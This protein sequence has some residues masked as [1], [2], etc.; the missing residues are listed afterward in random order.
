MKKLNMYLH[1]LCNSGCTGS[2][3]YILYY[4]SF[5]SSDHLGLSKAEVRMLSYMYAYI[6]PVI[7][8]AL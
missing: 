6:F 2:D 1:S 7:F 3:K 5:N 8:A 4:D